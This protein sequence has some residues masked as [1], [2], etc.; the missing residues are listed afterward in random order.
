VKGGFEERVV[1]RLADDTVARLG[2]DGC[3]KVPPR[4]E[5]LKV[6]TNWPCVLK[7]NDGSAS[8]SHPHGQTIDTLDDGKKVVLRG[9]SEQ[10]LLHVDDQQDVHCHYLVCLPPNVCRSAA[11]APTPAWLKADVA[12][13]GWSGLLDGAQIEPFAHG[14]G[15]VRLDLADPSVTAMRIECLGVWACVQVGDRSS[16]IADLPLGVGQER[17][18]DSEARGSGADIQAFDRRAADLDP[19]NDIRTKLCDP[20]TVGSNRLGCTV[21]MCCGCP[22]LGGHA[23]VLLGESHNG[24]SSYR[25]ELVRVRG[26]GGADPEV[27]VTTSPPSSIYPKVR[28]SITRVCIS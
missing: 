26:I 19:A 27:C 22:S 17:R 28:Y 2:L 3:Q 23:A 6:V 10:A 7:K 4:R 11:R 21:R 24:V 14:N 20:N 1:E 13:V 12:R 25:K 5:R 8:P 15:M 16:S 18:A 9:A